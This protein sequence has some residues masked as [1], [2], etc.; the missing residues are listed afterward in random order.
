MDAL[1]TAIW[2]FQAAWTLAV[3]ACASRFVRP[4]AD[5]PWLVGGHR[6]R[7]REDNGK[8]LHDE[9]LREG[10]AALWIADRKLE[11]RLREE[12]VP[13]LRRNSLAAKLA[14]LRA[15]VLAYSHGED[16]LDPF[17]RYRKKG[18]GLRVLLNHCVQQ[19]K[20]SG[21]FSREARALPPRAREKLRKSQVDFD[22]LP[23]ISPSEKATF[24][25]R[26][27][28]EAADR[29]LPFG[30]GA[31]LDAFRAMP[32]AVDGRLIV[33]FPTWRD[34]ASGRDELRE[35][36]EAVAF[37]EP[38]R[39]HLRERGMELAIV[40]HINS[41]D[42][43]LAS[44]DLV[45]FRSPSEIVPLLGE[46]CCF[47]SDYS[48]LIVDWLLL[49]R[50]FVLFAPDEERY[51]RERG[52]FNRPSDLGFGPVARTAGELVDLIVSGK[53]RDVAPYAEARLRRKREFFPDPMPESFAKST[54]EAILSRLP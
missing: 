44:D 43:G 45:S 32:K 37:S 51:E 13:V 40:R 12:G 14:I 49:D 10:R 6:G 2:P 16:D 50:P 41:K 47:V 54:V 28:K 23:A 22:L 9:L 7:E 24:E 31:H 8:A 39:K 21:L 34:T 48:S 30:G 35:A 3:W 38:L 52:F 25:L 26:F 42:A 11:K 18:L 20:S 15:P 29:I 27:G 19:L 36:I 1:H 5:A 4:R 33:W 46:A 17:L 53:W